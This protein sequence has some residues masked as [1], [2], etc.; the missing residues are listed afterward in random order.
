MNNISFRNVKTEKDWEILLDLEILAS[1]CSPYYFAVTNMADL[2]KF[3]GNSVI[4]LM[5]DGNKPIGQVAYELKNEVAEITGF[6]LS[7]DYRGR[8]LGT[9][10]F[11][12]AMEDLKNTKQIILM[13]H[14]ENSAALRIYLSAGFIIKAWKDNYYRNGQPRLRLELGKK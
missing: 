4:Y 6:V 14:P 12:K 9:V 10:L 1:K 13:T 5:F 7:P 8:G 3:V 11:E 2:K